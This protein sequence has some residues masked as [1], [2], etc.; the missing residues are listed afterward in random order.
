MGDMIRE[1]ALI[2]GPSGE[3][4]LKLFQQHAELMYF[5]AEI[6]KVET[7]R[8]EIKVVQAEQAAEGIPWWGLALGISGGTAIG[9]VLGVALGIAAGR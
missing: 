3:C 2:P 9:F 4:A 5:A 6:G 1:L 7:S 8:C